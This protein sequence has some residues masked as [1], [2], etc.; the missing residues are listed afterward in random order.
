MIYCA[1]ERFSIEQPIAKR[2]CTMVTDC[3]CRMAEIINDQ[4]SRTSR[5]PDDMS[6][7]EIDME[8]A[9]EANRELETSVP[10][11]R[12]MMDKIR[13]AA[14]AVGRNMKMLLLLAPFLGLTR[15]R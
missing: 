6:D 9:E 10:K 12:A 5:S 8:R 11:F 13:N 4:R 1:N 3:R 7:P 2:E 14:K 15:H